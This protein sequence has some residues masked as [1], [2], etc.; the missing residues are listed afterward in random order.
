MFFV[1]V[2]MQPWACMLLLR[3]V[4]HLGIKWGLLIYLLVWPS[5]TKCFF[6]SGITLVLGMHL[7]R[8]GEA[9]ESPES[10]GG[11]IFTQTH[12]PQ[13]CLLSEAFLKDSRSS[14]TCPFCWSQWCVSQLHQLPW[15]VLLDFS[16][17]C[18]CLD[19]PLTFPIH[20]LDRVQRLGLM[21]LV[22]SDRISLRPDCARQWLAISC[23]MAPYKHVLPQQPIPLPNGKKTWWQQ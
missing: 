16:R 21:V 2:A 11:P 4:A 8:K 7:W 22:F 5:F 9:V 17:L 20:W 14:H 18:L 13:L 15:S 23:P 3:N 10:L 1:D 6:V 19:L 12:H